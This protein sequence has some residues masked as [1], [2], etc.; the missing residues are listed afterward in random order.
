[1]HRGDWKQDRPVTRAWHVQFRALRKFLRW[2]NCAMTFDWYC[3]TSATLISNTI[4][5]FVSVDMQLIIKID[6]SNYHLMNSLLRPN[7]IISNE[8]YLYFWSSAIIRNNIRDAGRVCLILNGLFIYVTSRFPL[9]LTHRG[10]VK[11]K[12]LFI[13]AKVQ[14]NLSDYA[15]FRQ[16]SC[17]G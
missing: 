11:A 12:F 6:P 5:V 1:M 7:S 17:G 16:W 15:N 3:K 9:I 10:G 13:T 4:F 8:T 2:F 14:G